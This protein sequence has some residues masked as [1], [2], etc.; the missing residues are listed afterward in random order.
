M[1]LYTEDV[2]VH[3]SIP[4]IQLARLL[5]LQCS[6]QRNLLDE[7]SCDGFY[8]WALEVMSRFIDV[9]LSLLD[10]TRR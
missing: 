5:A 2:K 1:M 6:H 8:P 10:Y 3:K 7:S 4:I 9:R